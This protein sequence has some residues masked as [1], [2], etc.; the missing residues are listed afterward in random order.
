NSTQQ[1]KQELLD[2][3]HFSIFFKEGQG[4]PDTNH[5]QCWSG[6]ISGNR[7]LPC[8][9][10]PPPGLKIQHFYTN[11]LWGGGGGDYNKR[12]FWNYWL[13]GECP[14]PP[15]HRG[16]SVPYWLCLEDAALGASVG[17]SGTRS[18]EKMNLTAFLTRGT[19]AGALMSKLL[20]NL[21][22]AEVLSAQVHS[23]VLQGRWEDNVSGT[24]G[25]TRVCTALLHGQVCPFQDSTDGLCLLPG[26]ATV[27]FLDKAGLQE[28][29]WP[30]L[31]LEDHQEIVLGQL[32]LP[33][34]KESKP[35]APINNAGPGASTT[36]AGR[37]GACSGARVTCSHGCTMISTFSTSTSIST[38]TRG[39]ASSRNSAGATVSP[40]VPLSLSRDCQEST[41]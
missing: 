6:C 37:P 13:E 10:R 12:S 25:R 23:A 4:P 34:P 24:L 3:F 20:T 31:G 19:R 22:G 18:S 26:P 7:Q 21:P 29:A 40:R 8:P 5:G 39:R 30:G 11:N 32:V 17:S 28:F 2:G 9:A 33:E 41:Q 27:N 1:I 15:R 36:T 38:S 16:P 35:E 14:S